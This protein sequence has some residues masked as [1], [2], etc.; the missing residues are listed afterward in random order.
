MQPE[1]VSP[2]LVLI[3]PVLA[4][5]E[6]ARLA[7]SAWL[8]ERARLEQAAARR[9]E[10]YRQLALEPTDVVR[11]HAPVRVDEP[12]R[13]RDV[14]SLVRRALVPT[15]VIAGLLAGGA[16]AAILVTRNDGQGRTFAVAPVTSAAP[17]PGSAGNAA[18]ARHTASSLPTTLGTPHKRA[19]TSPVSATKTSRTRAATPSPRA[20]AGPHP[21]R[22]SVERKLLTRLMLA[23]RNGDVPRRFVDQRTGLIKNNVQVTCKPRG[24]RRFLCSVRLPKG[25]LS[26]VRYRKTL[27]GRDTFQWIARANS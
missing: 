13:A 25:R 1:P 18:T 20:N 27:T 6:R 7:D 22:A 5:R 11:P 17:S 9:Q 3:D 19:A 21:S 26:Y 12:A 14:A 16:Y 23:P 10:F 15:L 2:E 8:E 24:R 4:R